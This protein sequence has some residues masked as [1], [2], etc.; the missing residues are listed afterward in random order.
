MRKTQILHLDNDALSLF[1]MDSIIPALFQNNSDIEF[2]SLDCPIKCLSL[3]SLKYNKVDRIVMFCD[4]HLPNING[5][6]FVD[7]ITEMDTLGKV[8]LYVITEK[9]M[10]TEAETIKYSKLLKG[11]YKKP[12]NFIELKKILSEYTK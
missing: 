8:D 7:L 2:N 9:F 5:W 3:I 1:L 6:D 12:L 4:I 10:I 11:F